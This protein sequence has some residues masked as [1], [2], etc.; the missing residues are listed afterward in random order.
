M[1]GLVW[2]DYGAHIIMYT[3]NIS[4]FIYTNTYG[5][6]D[7]SLDY[8]LYG[9]TRVINGLETKIG[10]TLTSYGNKTYFD[11]ALEKATRT[12]YNRW[13]ADRITGYKGRPENEIIIYKSAF[14]DLKKTK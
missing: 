1:S 12:D 8:F 2:T 4:D 10:G 14:K 11:A 9:G 3:R 13:Q 6:V 7:A 5:E